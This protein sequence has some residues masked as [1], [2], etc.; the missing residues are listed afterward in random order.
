MPNNSPSSFKIFCLTPA[1]CSCT[2]CNAILTIFLCFSVL[3]YSTVLLS[4]FLPPCRLIFAI[5]LVDILPFLM[6]RIL[7]RL[8]FAI[9]L[10]DI[11]PFSCPVLF[12]SPDIC[13]NSSRFCLFSCPVFCHLIFALLLIDILPF[14][15]PVFCRK[16]EAFF[17]PSSV[18]GKSG[19]LQ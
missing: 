3:K 7:H 8:I 19:D 12:L 5:L 15:C 11:L 16:K 1:L 17:H 10:V 6:S 4:Q 18:N 14:S 9:L 13:P 2:V